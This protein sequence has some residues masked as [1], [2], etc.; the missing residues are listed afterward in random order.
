MAD[1]D[2]ATTVLSALMILLIAVAFIA[3][4][5]PVALEREAHR[6]TVEHETNC[7]HYGDAMNEWARQ[8][9]L[10]EPCGN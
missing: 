6:Q 1:Q 2:T 3:Y 9:N 7:R 10:A 4:V 5:I 8:K